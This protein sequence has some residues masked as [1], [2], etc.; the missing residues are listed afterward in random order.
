VLRHITSLRPFY[1]GDA[2]G[3]GGGGTPAPAAP[4]APANPSVAFANLM[5]RSSDAASLARQLFEEN[6]RYRTELRELQGRVPAQGAAVLT[7]EQAQAWAAYQQLGAPEAV[8]TTIAAHGSLQRDLQ[9]RDVAAASGYQLDVLRTLAADLAFE[10]K[11][12][13]KDGKAVKTVY[14]TPKGGQATPLET[15]ASEQWAAFLPALRPAAPA[16]QAAAPNTGATNPAASRGQTPQTAIDPKNPP[17]LS[18][19]SWK[20]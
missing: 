7:A 16:G 14:V 12:E 3:N 15:Y 2:G 5:E 17:R 13:T 6:F 20:Q 19:I 10:V 11:D 4:P 1:E 18:S 9:I 8:A